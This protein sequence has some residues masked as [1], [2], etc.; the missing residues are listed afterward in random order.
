MKSDFCPSNA[1]RIDGTKEFALMSAGFPY[2][3]TMPLLFE[4]KL[5]FI[6]EELVSSEMPPHV[7][8]GDV[9]A[10]F[11]LRVKR[12]LYLLKKSHYIEKG[13]DMYELW[14]C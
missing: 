12:E 9:G 6:F 13:L 11:A 14:L 2:V 8:G 5:F 1:V 10:A 3:R 4:R 7:K